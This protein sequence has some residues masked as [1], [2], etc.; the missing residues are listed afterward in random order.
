MTPINKNL[1]YVLC[2]FDTRGTVTEV[3]RQTGEQKQRPIKPEETVWVKYEQI[4]T[5]NYTTVSPEYSKFLQ[6]F[7]DQE[8]HDYI[9][10]G[11]RRVWTKPIT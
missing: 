7:K 3:N 9:N 10:E 8:Y 6:Q 1:Q 5:N 2:G 4:F 11:Y